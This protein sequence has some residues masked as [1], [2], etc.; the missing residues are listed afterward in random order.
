[1]WSALLGARPLPCP[2]HPLALHCVVLCPPLQ[3]QHLS[4]EG[5]SVVVVQENTHEGNIHQGCFAHPHVVGFKD[6]TAVRQEAY[7]QLLCYAS[8]RHALERV[9]LTLKQ[10]GMQ[11]SS[12]TGAT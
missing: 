7:I 3:L 1:M 4:K 11:A 9:V 10:G 12:E 2:V 8:K 5:L 6:D